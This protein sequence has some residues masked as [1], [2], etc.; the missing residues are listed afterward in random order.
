LARPAKRLAY[1]AL[2][3][4]YTL[5]AGVLGPFSG[6][7]VVTGLCLTG[8]AVYIAQMPVLDEPMPERRRA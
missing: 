7:A 4:S 2:A 6:V 1:A 8:V 5:T 3:V